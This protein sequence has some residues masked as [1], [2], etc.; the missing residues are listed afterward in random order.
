MNAIDPDVANVTCIY[1]LIITTDLTYSALGVNLAV[2]EEFD[3][4]RSAK[5]QF[6]Q[7]VMIYVPVIVNLDSLILL[8]YRLHKTTLQLND[9]LRD[10]IIGNWFNISSFDNYVF[11]VCKESQKEREE[12]LVYLLG[13]TV[14]Q[15]AQMTLWMQ[16]GTFEV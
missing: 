1:P 4:I 10:F 15:V 13:E 9:L 2:T 3:R 11:D 7:N 16:N 5:Y 14:N 12:G 6:L 8:S